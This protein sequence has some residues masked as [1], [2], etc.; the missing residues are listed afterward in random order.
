M[1]GPLLVTGGSGYLGRA[2]LASAEPRVVATHRSAGAAPLPGVEW[3]RLDVRD[4]AAVAACLDRVRPRAVIHTAYVQDGPEAWATNVTGSVN[5]AR[6]AARAGAPLVHVSTDVVFDGEKDGAYVEDDDPNPVTDYGRSKAEAELEVLASHPSALVVRTSLMAGAA[7]PGRQEQAVLAAA[8]GESETGFFTD[9]LRS[10]LLVQDLAAAL[11]ELAGRDASGVL[12]VGGPETV[13]RYELACL[14]A[15]AH[16]LPP[17]RIRRAR[18]AGSGLV[19]PANCALDSSRARALL[20]TPI[21]G[22]S[23]LGRVADDQPRP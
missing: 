4:E 22:V 21:R 7:V 8:R 1:S 17:E 23:E 18:L 13:S 12:H 2:I 6:A 9:E 3:V 5:V 19:R 20:R 15:G 11:V 16:G 10:P 14:I